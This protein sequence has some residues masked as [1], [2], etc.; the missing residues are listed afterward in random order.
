MNK[1]E[2]LL[3]DEQMAQLENC[4]K[5][6]KCEPADLASDVLVMFLTQVTA[7]IVNLPKAKADE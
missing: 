4:A 6:R 1:I 2:I 7:P 5:I 3:N